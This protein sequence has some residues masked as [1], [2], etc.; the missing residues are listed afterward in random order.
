MTN[1][2]AVGHYKPLVDFTKKRS[3]QHIIPPDNSAAVQENL[4]RLKRKG[5]LS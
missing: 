3:S 5:T 2:P 1:V 4:K